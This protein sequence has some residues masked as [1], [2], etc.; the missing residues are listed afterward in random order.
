MILDNTQRKQSMHQYPLKRIAFVKL[1]PQGKSYA[2]L[3]EREDLIIGDRVEVEMHAGTK[4]AFSMNGII[5]DISFQRWNCSCHVGYHCDE[6]S[7]S[8]DTANS[9]ELTQHVHPRNQS[10]KPSSLG[11]K[12]RQHI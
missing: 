10:K 5:T 8:I 6:V 7:Y 1:S 9:F 3:C 2:M 11:D 4:H 12:K